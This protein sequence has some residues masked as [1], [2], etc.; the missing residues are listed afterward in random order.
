VVSARPGYDEGPARSQSAIGRLRRGVSLRAA[1]IEVDRSIAAVA[2][3][4]AAGYRAGTVR[5]SLSPL[6]S[7]GGERREAGAGPEYHLPRG[8]LEAEW[9]ESELGSLCRS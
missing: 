7:R 9:G 2:A 8:W 4:H 1:Q 6:R 3:A 5:L